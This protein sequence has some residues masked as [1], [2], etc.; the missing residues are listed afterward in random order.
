MIEPDQRIEA[1]LSEIPQSQQ[2]LFRCTWCANH[3]NLTTYFEDSRVSTQIKSC[4]GLCL[5]MSI[6]PSRLPFAEGIMG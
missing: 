6:I 3:H 1:R 4:E 5:D 2:K